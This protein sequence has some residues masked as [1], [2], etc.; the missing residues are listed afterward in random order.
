MA[1]LFDV[2]SEA[3][4]QQAAAAQTQAAKQ[5][6]KKSNKAL[7]KGFDRAIMAY[8]ES[9]KPWQQLY[10]QGQQG[11]QTYG[12]AVGVNGA[13]GQARA[14]Q[15]F[16]TDPGYQ[17]QQEQGMDA[18]SRTNAA[19][20]MTSSGNNIQDILRFSQGLAD[21]SYNQYV[22]RLAPYLNQPFTA[23]AGQSGVYGQAADAAM[24]TGMA[25]SNVAQNT[26]GTI[27]QAQANAAM[28]PYNASANMWGSIL[29]LAG[30]GAN[31]AG[32]YYGS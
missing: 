31:A 13:E 26:Y 2:F 17:F 3:P 30:A 16:Q 23:A 9:I 14:R 5:G 21:Q 15:N 20:G 12:D 4:A 6:S 24:N 18:L 1:G 25:K 27:G 29:G 11:Y 7:D 8:G 19:R 10:G 22:N 32:A 28:A